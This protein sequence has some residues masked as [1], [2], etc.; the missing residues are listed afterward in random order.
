MNWEYCFRSFTKNGISMDTAMET[1][2]DLANS[3]GLDGWEM[4]GFTTIFTPSHPAA[5][6]V[7]T[8]AFKRHIG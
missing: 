2:Q 7:Y 5:V 8:L 3:L 4:C 1:M 6:M